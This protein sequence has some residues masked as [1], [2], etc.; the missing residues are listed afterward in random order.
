MDKVMGH[1]LMHAI[2]LCQVTTNPVHNCLHLACTEI[3][4]KNLSSKCSFFKELPRILVQAG[5][6]VQGRRANCVQRRALLSMHANPQCTAWALD[7]VQAAM[8]NACLIIIPF[9]DIRIKEII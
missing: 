5:E 4:A 2:D 6:Q 9:V 8:P 7:Y 1:K 3:Q